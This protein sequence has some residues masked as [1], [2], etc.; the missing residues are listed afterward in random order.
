[1][2]TKPKPQDNTGAIYLLLFVMLLVWAPFGV[3]LGLV[4]G[5]IFSQHRQRLVI[6]GGL[7]LACLALGYFVYFEQIK[8]LIALPQALIVQLITRKI[9]FSQALEQVMPLWKMT[10]VIGPALPLALAL[11]RPQSIEEKAAA[12]AKQ[13][14]MQ[15]KGQQQRAVHTASKSAPLALN[16][17][18][19]L[20]RVVRGDLAEITRNGWLLFP[21]KYLMRHALLI[22]S[23]GS[24]K[25]ET[26]MR[27]VEVAVSKG[28]QVLYL[29]FKGDYPTMERFAGI[30]QGERLLYPD[31]MY[32]GWVG[33]ANSLLN[34]L[35]GIVDYAEP[36]YK[37]GA[38]LLLGLACF[39][40]GGPPR[41]SEELLERLNRENLIALYADDPV[42][43][44]Q[45]QAIDKKVFEGVQ[46]RY[47][48]FFLMLR[49]QLDGHASFDDCDAAYML[50]DGTT[51]K[52]EAGS[53]GRFFVEELAQYASR[54]ERSQQV[55]CIIDEFSAIG[56]EA[57]ASNLLERMRS[58]G[59]AVVIT[60]QSYAGLGEHADRM[61]D[62]A[63]TVILHQSSDP[64]QL[65]ARAGTKQRLEAGYQIQDG[66]TTGMGTVRMQDSYRVSPNEV[67]Q[68][69]V[70][71]AF[72]IFG[73]R[74]AHIAIPRSPHAGE[75]EQS[76]KEFRY[77][78]RIEKPKRLERKAA[79]ATPQAPQAKP[80]APK[81]LQ[82]KPEAP[83]PL[84]AKP[85]APKPLQAKPEAPKPLQAKP[86]A[87]KPPTREQKPLPPPIKP[88][89][90]P[91]RPPAAPPEAPQAPEAKPEA[92]KPPKPPTPP[93]G[94]EA[95]PEAPKPPA[96]PQAPEAK[97]E[98]PKPPKPPAA[99]L[100]APEAKPEAPK[101]P[102]APQAPEAK[103][104][105]PKPP[106]PPTPPAGPEVKKV[107]LKRKK[108]D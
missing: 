47:S 21:D 13:K 41:C 56:R 108:E 24:G 2:E 65:A 69:P 102:A 100:Q 63:G 89:P 59:V 98:A 5:V 93:A 3:L 25:T 34:R 68:L 72:V 28:W 78:R 57:D 105:A 8:E 9:D 45:I 77:V 91:P 15:A 106:K 40:K 14:E 61:L 42:R 67:R 88:Q 10:W 86:E 82:A 73:G 11:L 99:P 44:Q 101:P 70:G 30:V 38:K 64:E 49:N 96:A 46:L 103:P 60:S 37:D 1:M 90:L 53:L 81:P 66:N 33:D 75:Q 55:L 51:L 22:G 92:P 94:P 18:M 104:E 26:A 12:E 97:P 87:P 107:Q 43:I 20:G 79:P 23:S 54:K 7:L 4:V 48:S 16:N 39:A 84:Q 29:D 19:V 31:R 36:Y 32:N 6:W 95:K 71:Q 50:V 85:E 80:E 62:A 74:A 17:D 27:L 58:F 83:K 52:E 76:G 35:M